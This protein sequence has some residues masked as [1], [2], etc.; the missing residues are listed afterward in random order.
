MLPAFNL[1]LLDLWL[2]QIAAVW[3]HKS[4]RLLLQESE[5]DEEKTFSDKAYRY[6]LIANPLLVLLMRLPSATTWVC[7]SCS[8]RHIC[9]FPLLFNVEKRKT[10][11]KHS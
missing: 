2:L 7:G 4:S 11:M 10:K 9:F 6:W 8:T 1:S 3:V 5:K